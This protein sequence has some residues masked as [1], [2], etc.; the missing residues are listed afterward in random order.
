[1]TPPRILECTLRDG[2]YAINFQFTAADTSVI[3]GALEDVGFD[4]IEVGHGIGLGASERG[5]GVAAETD[6]TYMKATAETLRKAAWGMFCI[7]GIATLDHIDMAAD[8]GMTFIRVGTNVTE[9]D[10]AKPFI[11]RAIAHGMTVYANFM[12]SYASPPEEFAALTARAA[13]FGVDA[14]YLVDSAG[15]MFPDDIRRYV[16]AVRQRTAVA[17]GFHGHH[18]LGMGVANA[19]AAAEAGV[20]IIDSSLQGFG[21][22]SGNTPTEQLL[23]AL[24]RRGLAVG[25]DPI[26]VMDIGEKYIQP[27]IDA[28]GHN[29]I[30]TVS[31]YAQFHSSYMGVIREFA[32]K[33]RIDPRRLI[34]AICAV[35]KVDAPRDLVEQLAA[36]LAAEAA[37]NEPLTSRFHL[38]RYHGAEQGS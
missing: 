1:M 14:V 28:R 33:Y 35:N 34:I 25:I 37:L 10:Q 4:L 31:G 36:R 12:K 13:G 19:L 23:C 9:V 8:H 21:R 5:M 38:E 29:S 16:D 6:E 17:L 15:G 2:S 30:D 24:E 22:S 18:N 3:V 32:S 20:A 11:E 7:P 26:R 27:L